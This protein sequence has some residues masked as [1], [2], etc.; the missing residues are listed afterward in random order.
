MNKIPE[1]KIKRSIVF[2]KA[3]KDKIFRENFY[4]GGIIS[5][6]KNCQTL[7]KKL[8]RTQIKVFFIHGL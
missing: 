5:V 6:L 8:K 7:I 2:I 1:R 4:Q 3:S